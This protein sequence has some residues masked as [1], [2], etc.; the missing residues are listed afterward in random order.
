M[1]FFLGSAQMISNVIRIIS[2]L[3]IARLILPEIL[4]LFNGF[5]IIIGYLPILQLGIMNGLNRELPFL[6]GKGENERAK[7]FASV[8]QFWELL[9]GFISFSILFALSIVKLFQGNHL[10]FFGYLTYAF[11]AFHYFYSTNYLQILYRTNRDFN[12]LSV[13]SL[14]VSSSSLLLIVFVWKWG[15]YGLGTRLLLTYA[16]ELILL[17]KFRPLKVK[18]FFDKSIFKELLKVGIPIF[19]VGYI[20][21]LWGVLQNTIV[22]K[23]GGA[24]QFGYFSLAIMVEGSLAILIGAVNQVVY[25]KLSFEYGKGTLYNKLIKIILK[26]VAIVFLILVPSV[27]IMWYAL[28]Y[29]VTWLLPQY[30]EGIYAAQWTLITLLVSIFGAFNLIFNVV[31][32]QKDYLITIIVGILSFVFVLYILYINKGFD[33]VIFPQ[34][35]LIGKLVQIIS[36]F[37]F[38]RRYRNIINMETVHDAS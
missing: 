2:G 36:A 37:F 21:S 27:I 38:I 32:K 19:I 33:L 12:K 7:Q 18:P 20:F 11:V 16:I 13:I 10:H 22:F 4:G 9:I 28:P 3:I 29:F 35:M 5:G 26:P 34:A 31:K 14:I 8:A 15:F 6:F 23:F 24:Q 1:I 17:Y 25:P 30:V